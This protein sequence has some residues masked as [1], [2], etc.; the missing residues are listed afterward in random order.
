MLEEAGYKV[1]CIWECEWNKIKNTLENRT[2]LEEQARNQHIN[3]RDA[4]FGGRTEGFK[5]YFKCNEKQKVFYHDVVSLYPTVNALDPYAIGFRRPI[6][7]SNKEE[8]IHRI[9]SGDF[10]GVVKADIT[11]PKDLYLPVLPDNSDGKLLF[12]LNPLVKK[13]YASV[14]LK[15][16]LEKGY[17]IDKIYAAYEYDKMEGLMKQY[18]GSFLKM[19]IENS[20]VKTQE[21]CDEINNSHKA[22]GFDFEVKPEDT[23]KNPGLRQ[24]AKICLNSLWGKFGQRSTLSSYDFY[25]DFNKLLLKMNDETVKTKRWHIVNKNCVELRYENDMDIGVEA[26]YIS[27]ITAVFTTANARMRLYEMLDWLHPSQVLYC[28]TDSV[29]FVYDETNPEHKAPLNSPSNPETVR[30]GNGLGEWEDEFKGGWIT[31]LVI[32]GAKSYAYVTNTGKTVIKQKG[33]TLDKA[34]SSVVTFET[35]KDMVLNNTTI[36][37]EKRFQFRWNNETKDIETKF[38]PKTIRSTLMEKRDLSNYDTLPF[39]YSV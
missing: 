8:L 4:L 37:T 6:N 11:P 21:E 31:E 24:V 33:I 9:A 20:G 29:M 27:E 28:D 25:Y 10:F 36:E 26:E 38:V 39:G 7:V 13:T 2:E 1:E 5:S 12:H 34:N 23:K 15:K 35:I 17:V 22:L 3:V 19:K 32:G 30:F 16:A 14:E 18:V